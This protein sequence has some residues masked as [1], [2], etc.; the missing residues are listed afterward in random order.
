[1]PQVPLHRKLLDELDDVDRSF[2]RARL[3]K[4]LQD[5]TV[6]SFVPLSDLSSDSDSDMS[7]ISSISSISSVLSFDLDDQASI[8]LS[9]SLSF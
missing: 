9:L 2:K 3:S 4:Y 1:M 5:M 8:H 6:K 7:S